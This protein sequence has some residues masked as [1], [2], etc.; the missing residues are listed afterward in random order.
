MGNPLTEYGEAVRA[1]VKG[2]RGKAAE[3]LAQAFGAEKVTTPISTSLDA[4]LE[5]PP[6]LADG[7]LRL[8]TNE[9]AKRR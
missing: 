2:D 1:N 7:L 4:L 6:M 9:S 3:K 5:P 8:M